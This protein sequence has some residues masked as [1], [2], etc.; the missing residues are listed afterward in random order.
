[1]WSRDPT[2]VVGD[3]RG[4]DQVVQ[5]RHR[6]YGWH[7]APSTIGPGRQLNR[8]VLRSRSRYDSAVPEL[9]SALEDV[10]KAVDHTLGVSWLDPEPRYDLIA[11]NDGDYVW[12]H[13]DSTPDFH[14]EHALKRH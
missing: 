14:P 8:D 1:M 13:Q 5:T 6:R 3:L 10:R 12:P 4:R 2:D 11:S 7:P 9:L